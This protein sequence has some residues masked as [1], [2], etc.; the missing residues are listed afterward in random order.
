MRFKGLFIVLF[1]LLTSAC[2]TGGG[3]KVGGVRTYFFDSPSVVVI[4]ATRF[5]GEILLNDEVVQTIGV[6]QVARIRLG[7][8]VRNNILIFRAFTV[9]EKGASYLEGISTMQAQNYGGNN[10]QEWRI[11]DVQPIR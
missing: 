11:T 6:G 1:V 5:H 2:A 9:D 3:I 8:L 4:N 10:V 7:H